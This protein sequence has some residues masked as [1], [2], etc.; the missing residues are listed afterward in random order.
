MTPQEC[1]LNLPFIFA[2]VAR[3]ILVFCWEK[4][5]RI[6]AL[7]VSKKV[8]LRYHAH[9][10]FILVFVESSLVSLATRP[11]WFVGQ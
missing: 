6:K 4:Q 1:P 10:R 7:N 3:P 8:L 5:S 11:G 2:E 9:V